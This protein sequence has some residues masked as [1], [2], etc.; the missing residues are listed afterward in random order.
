MDELQ[1]VRRQSFYCQILIVLVSLGTLRLWMAP[2]D[3]LPAAQA[4]R[5][6]SRGGVPDSGAQRQQ[7]I[8]ATEKTNALLQD[9]LNHL[10]KGPVPVAVQGVEAATSA[11]GPRH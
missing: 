8:R 4:Q 7:M 1:A 11:K 5:V 3:I 6:Q 9:I 2:V 10:K